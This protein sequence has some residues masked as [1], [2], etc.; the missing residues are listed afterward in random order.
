MKIKLT[1]QKLKFNGS[2]N[3]HLRASVMAAAAVFTHLAFRRTFFLQNSRR[4]CVLETFAFRGVRNV[5]KYQFGRTRFPKIARLFAFRLR[6]GYRE[7]FFVFP[8]EFVRARIYTHGVANFFARF[9][10]SWIKNLFLCEKVNLCDTKDVQKCGAIRYPALFTSE[11][12]RADEVWWVY[13]Y[14]HILCLF[15]AMCFVVWN[16]F[17]FGIMKVYIVYW[18]DVCRAHL[19]HI[20]MCAGQHNRLLILILLVKIRENSVFQVS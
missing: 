11:V 8:F 20:Y 6:R 2:A 7:K 14:L 17:F 12:E 19:P 5:H 16:V 3:F 18:T 4:E 9:S 10:L 15:V 1:N 13:F